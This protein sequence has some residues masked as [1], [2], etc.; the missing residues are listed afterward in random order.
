MVSIGFTAPLSGPQAIVGVPMCRAAALAVE[1]HNA[2]CPAEA[3][4]GLRPIDDG[5]TAAGA[6]AAAQA[7]ID[8][9]AVVGVVGHKNSEPC[10][11]AGSLYAAAGLA[12]IAPSATNSALAAQGWPT[13]FRV[14]ADNARQ[15][16]MACRAIAALGI[17]HVAVVHDASAYGQPLAE[18]AME[19]L[20]AR[21]IAVPTVV[22]LP[23]G[24]T[25]SATVAAVAAAL[26]DGPAELIYGGLTEVEGALLLRE[27]RELRQRGSAIAYMGAEGG[28]SA[29]LLQLAG[30][31]AH[32]TLHTY[33]GVDPDTWPAAAEFARL[34]RERYGESPGGF[35]AECYDAAGLLLRAIAT[36]SAPTR[37]AVLRALHE[38]APYAGAT[39]AIA[40]DARGERRD[41]AVSLWRA[42]EGRM[43]I[44]TLEELAERGQ[45][46]SA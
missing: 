35:A 5:A 6:R 21:G 27:L 8:D 41:A 40:F 42:R 7:L 29:A 43:E 28:R 3:R 45:Q 34:Y 46:W 44:V 19:G 31:D 32:G 14:C 18:A 10:M 9:P 26:L 30:A 33:A 17:G 11:A 37:Q 4:V 22:E 16:E 1:R 23:V 36:S 2:T 12:Q 25:D 39:G 24:T 15:A 20:A 38:L 13:F